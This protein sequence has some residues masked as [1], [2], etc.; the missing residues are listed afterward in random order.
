MR[1]KR[2]LSFFVFATLGWGQ[3]TAQQNWAAV[4]CFELKAGDGIGVMFIDSVHNEIILNSSWSYQVCNTTYKAIFAYNGQTFHDLDVGINTHDPNPYLG[5]P[6]LNGCIA[7]NNKTIFTGN[8]RSVGSN[9]LN[10]RSIA[11]WNGTTWD[12][13]PHSF[14]SNTLSSPNIGGFSRLLKHDGKLWM[15]ANFDSTGN[16]FTSTPFIYN[17]STF[18]PIPSI[19]VTN[20]S[21][22]TE[23]IMY[24]NKLVVAGNFYNYPNF[25]FYRL[26]QFDGTSWAEVG[27]GVRGGLSAP[28]DIAIFNDT[29]YIGGAFP[30]SAGNAG[31]YLMKWDGTQLMDA[32]FGDFC[33]YGAIYKLLPYRN[34]L[35]AFG[36]FLCAANQKAFGVAYYENGV[37]KVPQ[38]SIDMA[39]ADAVVYN[40]AIYISG[41]FNSI[42]GDSSIRKFA[43]L[44]CPDFDAASGCIS[45]LKEHP[46]KPEIKVFPNPSRDKLF[47]DFEQGTA[48]D[49]ISLVNPL[50]QEVYIRLNP[51]QRQE[52]NLSHLP[53]GIYFLKAENRQGQGVFKVVKE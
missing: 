36:T 4:P 11:V 5:S 37:W 29:L 14:W 27:G 17:G 52:V 43:K 18:S 26:A 51:E 12:T 3:I 19:P 47:L 39:V 42:N 16:N 2:I 6:V 45:G 35:Y 40:D 33:G 49:K 32:G 20:P 25:D 53:A 22:I 31:N 50:G 1:P 38:D 41:Y 15:F 13:F 23:A 28:Q 9:T 24:K 48:I 10:S 21:A 8:I 44:M 34:K 46:G 30:K 7:Y